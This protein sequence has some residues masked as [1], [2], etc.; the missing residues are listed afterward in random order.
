MFHIPE[1]NSRIYWILKEIDRDMAKTAQGLGCG[2]CKGPLDRSDFRRKPRGI[3]EGISEEFSVRYSLCCRKE[4]C[5][6][7]DTPGSVRFLGQ[8]VFIMFF[9]VLASSV[10]SKLSS[11]VTAKTGVSGQTLRRWRIYWLEEFPK[12]PFWRQVRG[13]LMPPPDPSQLPAGIL[14]S[15][16]VGLDD[17]FALIPVLRFLAPISRSRRERISG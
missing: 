4:G 13:L 5:R 3:P 15:F 9:L 14:R 6:R 7:R 8:K 17:P 11:Q 1:A 12:S 2:F 16:G 10:S